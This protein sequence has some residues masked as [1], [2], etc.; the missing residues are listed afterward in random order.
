MKSYLD[1][2]QHIFDNGYT[3]MDRTGTGTIGVFG[4]QLRHSMKDGFPLLTTK[5][6]FTKGIIVELLWFLR[7]ET[8]I[9]PL[10]QNG[11]RIW[12]QW[13]YKNYL[14]LM[15][16]NRKPGAWI[17]PFTLEQ[18]EE[19]I[20]LDK[21]FAE[22]YG[23]LGPVYGSQWRAWPGQIKKFK[24][25]EQPN[26]YYYYPNN[27]L[28]VHEGSL[29]QE[30]IDQIELLMND[31][32]KNPL[33]RRHIVT[34]WNPAE[35]DEMIVSGLP[36]CHCLWQVNCRPLSDDEREAIAIERKV[37]ILDTFSMDEIRKVWDDANVPKYYLD[38]Q[39]YQRSCDTF[40]GVPFNIASYSLLLHMLA[41]QVNMIPGD[42]IHSYGDLH[43][44]SNHFEQ[45]KE[46]LTRKPYPLPKLKLNKAPDIYSYKLED[47]VFEDYQ[48]HG[49][50][51]APIAV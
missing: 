38:L 29:Y 40:L 42:F 43:I 30:R 7:G 34:A 15:E 41:Q 51:K 10:L 6:M 27:W 32:R 37:D 17:T 39:L 13:P 46:Q 2:V 45:A 18:F 12:T 33:S 25:N 16:E 1:M 48:S 21:T 50:I 23:D 31:L 49:S 20:V 24:H 5:K 19:Q 44:Y 28:P 3:K 35:L 26:G 14:K 9:R 36:P 22:R 47:F 8:N 11:V 4:Y